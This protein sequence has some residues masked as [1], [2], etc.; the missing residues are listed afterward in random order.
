MGKV[1][2]STA[3]LRFVNGRNDSPTYMRGMLDYLTDPV[4]TDNGRLIATQ[5]CSHNNILADILMNKKLHHKTHGKQGV[6]FVLSSPPIG[7]AKSP[8]EL[9]RTVCEIVGTIYPDYMSV[10]TVHT[11][12]SVLH[13]HV[14]MDAVNACT[15][16]KFSQGPADL[17]RIKQR[18]NS[19]L[20]AHGFEIIRMSANDF[21]DRTDYSKVTGFDFLEL[22]E[23][24]LISETDV[25]A[26]TL[27]D[28]K[29]SSTDYD[30]IRND[31]YWPMPNQ[32]EGRNGGSTTMRTYNDLVREAQ[33]PANES[34][35]GLTEQNVPATAFQTTNTYPNTAV[36]TGPTFRIKGSYS[37]DLSGL[38]DLVTSTVAQAQEH[39]RESASLALAMQAK[40]QDSGHFTNVALVAGS[41]F[42]INLTPAFNNRY[43][44]L[45]GNDYDPTNN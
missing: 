20:Q 33:Q 29:S 23:S 4:K 37:S 19:I 41:I 30:V 26:V 18:T 28:E 44:T 12:S 13:S 22:D 10:I 24:T 16:R 8:E 25:Q 1:D 27:K 6:H 5:G 11:D 36:V 43:V 40:A 7:G 15:G 2:L 14:L 21:V 42:D 9:L 3:I 17:N 32:F 39:E 35:F 38:S 31:W 45:D 34:T